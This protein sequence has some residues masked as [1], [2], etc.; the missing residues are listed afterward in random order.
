MKKI[1]YFTILM[2]LICTL[3]GCSCNHEWTE[4]TCTEPKTCSKCGETKGEALGHDEN[5]QEYSKID[6]VNATITYETKCSRCNEIL[7][8]R[9]EDIKSFIKNN[10]FN[11]TP[12]EFS[13]R[14]DDQLDGMSD[15][16]LVAK[17]TDNDSGDFIVAIG[18]STSNKAV[19]A[20]MFNQNSSSFVSYDNRDNSGFQGVLGMLYDDDSLAR[21]LLSTVLTFDPSLSFNEG[22]DIATSIFKRSSY[23]K[24][25]ITYVVT[26]SNG[27]YLIGVSAK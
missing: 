20:F 4:A 12:N 6:N 11:L 21:V 23:I 19:A 13:E 9:E 8:S 15:N 26:R 2:M 5:S 24:N 17:T 18:D 27:S 16:T 7:D 10:S 25:G 14:I 3:S 22:K 1:L